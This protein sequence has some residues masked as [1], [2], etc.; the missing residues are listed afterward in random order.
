MKN[1][2]IIIAL[3]FLFALGGACG[4]GVMDDSGDHSS[5]SNVKKDS[6]SSPM[7]ANAVTPG[8]GTS[9]PYNANI[10]NAGPINSANASTNANRANQ[11]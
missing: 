7:P 6:L 11:P 4:G 1:K 3:V 2:L 5:N 10:A 9:N 8:S